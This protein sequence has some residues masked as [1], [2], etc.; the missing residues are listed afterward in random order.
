[1][2]IK[3]ISGSYGYHGKFGVKLKDSSSAPFEVS[4]KEGERLI[5]AGVAEA[6]GNDVATAVP[7]DE[8][9][10]TCVDM[11]KEE[12]AETGENDDILDT[13]SLN[14]LIRVAK[15][16]GITFKKRPSK[17]DAIKAL[18]AVRDQFPGMTAEDFE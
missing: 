11:G 5:H 2:I 13:L 9:K 8:P 16:N 4:D 10:P 7:K 1:M 14:E 15:E 18:R 3:I 17:A 6:V 12:N